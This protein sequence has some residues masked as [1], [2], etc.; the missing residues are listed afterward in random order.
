MQPT[1][2]ENLA[3]AQQIATLDLTDLSAF[4]SALQAIELAHA[5]GLTAMQVCVLVDAASGVPI[6]VARERAEAAFAASARDGAGQPAP[7]LTALQA[8]AAPDSGS[9]ALP[10]RDPLLRGGR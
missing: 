5:E 1:H 4:N 7:A 8:G 2:P 3:L 6:S 9:I 10:Q